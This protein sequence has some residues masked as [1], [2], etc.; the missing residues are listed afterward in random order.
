MSST[1]AKP[2]TWDAIPADYRREWQEVIR[3]DECLAH[4]QESGDETPWY[5]TAENRWASR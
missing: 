2:L 3:T 5:R 4:V 1:A